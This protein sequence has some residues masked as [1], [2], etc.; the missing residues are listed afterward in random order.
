MSFAELVRDKSVS[1]VPTLKRTESMKQ[2]SP[3]LQTD[4]EPLITLVRQM[5]YTVWGNKYSRR[6]TDNILK[7]KK[8]STKNSCVLTHT[9]PPPRHTGCTS[10]SD[11]AEAGGR[12]IKLSTAIYKK[13]SALFRNQMRQRHENQYCSCLCEQW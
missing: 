8:K 13:K 11:T 5:A 3:P 1:V 10:Y 4:K 7:K 12:T 6:Q 9:P 2:S